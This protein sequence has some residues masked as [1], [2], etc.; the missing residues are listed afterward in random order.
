MK[1]K[2]KVNAGGITNNHNET[3]AR[4]QV[5]TSLRAGAIE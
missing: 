3:P 2:T 1:T 5:K 4:I